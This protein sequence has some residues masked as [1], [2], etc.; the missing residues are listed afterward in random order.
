MTTDYLTRFFAVLDVSGSMFTG[1][2]P[3]LDW[4]YWLDDAIPA[5]PGGTKVESAAPNRP[6]SDSGA[7]GLVLRYT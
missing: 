4:H 1:G 6:E 2:G 5:M 7:V 3:L